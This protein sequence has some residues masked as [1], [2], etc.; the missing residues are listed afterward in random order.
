MLAVS[1]TWIH[2]Y[3]FLHIFIR[4]RQSEINYCLK[5]NSFKTDT[6]DKGK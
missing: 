2:Q 4:T 3:T 5:D 6:R 1:V